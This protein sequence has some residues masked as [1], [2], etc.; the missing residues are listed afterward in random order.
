M[1]I[2]AIFATVACLVASAALA[3]APAPAVRIDQAWVRATPPGAP[4]GAAYLTI[5]N[6]GKVPDRLLGGAAAGVKRVEIHE[7]SMAGGVMRMRQLPDGLPIPA[8]GGV[9]LKPGGYHIML[10]GLDQPLKAGET[11]PLTL[12]F[13]KAGEIVLRAPIKTPPAAGAH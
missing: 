3:A 7:M 1:K 12:K 4:A 8:G 13:E 6:T 2:A 9:S 11:L 10:I 5:T